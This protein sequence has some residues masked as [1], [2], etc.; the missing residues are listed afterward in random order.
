MSE[1]SLGVLGW[2]EQVFFGLMELSFLSTP[3]YLVLVLA[4][5][6]YPDAVPIAGLLAIATGSIVIALTRNGAVAVGEWPRRGELTTM[7]FR[8][9]YFSLVFIAAT[10]GVAY[11]THAVGSWW[12]T[13]LGAPVQALGL[14][15]FP[16]AYYQVYG[17]PRVK[18]A[19]R[20]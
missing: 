20:I 12:L 18:P 19:Q 5:E 14:A 17:T 6:V 8:L 10:M 1:E 9:A 16:T 7:P 11:V 4:Q 13:L 3:A 2:L 15:A